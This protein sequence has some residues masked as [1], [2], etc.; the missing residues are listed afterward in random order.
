MSQEVLIVVDTTTRVVTQ[1]LPVSVYNTGLTGSRSSDCE[2]GSNG[3]PDDLEPHMHGLQMDPVTG[4]LY[5]SD[6][7]EHCF[8]EGTYIVTHN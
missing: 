8:Y 7:G 3:V 6:E 4:N 1:V 5:L 2:V